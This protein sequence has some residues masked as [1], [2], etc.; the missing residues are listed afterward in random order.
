MADVRTVSGEQL[1]LRYEARPHRP[2]ALLFAGVGTVFVVGG[3]SL[4]A[5]GDPQRDALIALAFGMVAITVSVGLVAAFPSVTATFDRARRTLTL[6]ES[7]PARRRLVTR[8]LDDVAEVDVVSESGAEGR[9]HHVV[10]W[11][12]TGEA[13]VLDPAGEDARDDAERDADEVRRFLDSAKRS[14]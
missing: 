3:F 13:L 5:R 12:A 2:L 14:A 6:S 11:L 10:V 4:V 9:A 7:S 1:V 8:A